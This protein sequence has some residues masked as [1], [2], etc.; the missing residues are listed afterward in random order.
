MKSIELSEVEALAPH[1]QPGESEPL[2]VTKDGQTVAA[3]VPTNETD[4][5]DLL[6]SVNVRFQAILNQS[7]RRMR[8]EGV[9]SA[10]EVRKQLGLK[11]N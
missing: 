11:S 9:V 7:Q 4:V 10:S 3:I 2:V 1:L 5:E 6:L 8:E